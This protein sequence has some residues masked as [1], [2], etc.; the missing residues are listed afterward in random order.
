MNEER[1]IL[2][3]PYLISH[4]WDTIEKQIRKADD[5]TVT[6]D[7]IREAL[8]EDPLSYDVWVYL[9]TDNKIAYSMIGQLLSK[10]YFIP[11]IAK[12]D[13]YK[14]EGDPYPLMFKEAASRAKYLGATTFSFIGGLF[15][16]K[17]LSDL[18][19]QIKEYFYE[20]DLCDASEEVC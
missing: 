7:D 20:A 13:E 2:L 3:P 10:S 8:E 18:G 19:F 16:E 5:N 1:F 4:H 15:W 14:V 17:K 6:V 12:S 9:T 11:R